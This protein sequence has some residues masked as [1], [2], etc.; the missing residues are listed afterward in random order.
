MVFL[1]PSLQTR[2]GNFKSN[3]G[4]E[5]CQLAGTKKFR[6]SPYH[7]QMNEQCEEFNS[8]LIS[9]LEILPEQGKSQWN[10]QVVTLVHAY[11]CQRNTTTSFSLYFLCF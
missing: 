5:L 1:K 10:N 8:T 7:P 9:M 2:D 11:N 4:A 6:T 3:L